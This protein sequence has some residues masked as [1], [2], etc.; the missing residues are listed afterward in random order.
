M[1]YHLLRW[2]R[3][4]TGDRGSCPECHM[5]LWTSRTEPQLSHMGPMMPSSWDILSSQRSFRSPSERFPWM[6]TPCMHKKFPKERSQE[7]R[8]RVLKREGPPP[9]SSWFQISLSTPRPPSWPH[10]PH[11]LRCHG[12]HLGHQGLNTLLKEEWGEV[13]VSRSA[14]KRLKLGI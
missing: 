13:V 2:Y 9:Q 3:R 4:E 12:G 5:W 6:A 1:P 10:P 11:L 7:T 14:H 8:S